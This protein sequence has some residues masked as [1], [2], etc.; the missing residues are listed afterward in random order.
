[1][2]VAQRSGR[3]RY[4]LVLLILTALA[5]LTLD[6]REFGPLG[7]AQSAVRDF[8]Q[9]GVNAVDTL[10]G[11]VA[12]VWTIM[13]V[14]NDLRNENVQLEAELDQLRSADITR[15]ATNAAL[16]SLL[17]ATEV[18]YLTDVEG[19]TAS[20]LRDA[21]GNFNDDMI[22]VDVGRRDGVTAG[23]AVVTG[24]GLV[25]RINDVDFSSSTVTTV[26]DP[27]LTI[28]V[29]L[30]DTGEVGLGHGVAGQ[31]ELFVV[32]TGLRWPESGDPAELPAIGSSVVTAAA[33]RY[34]ADVPVG[35]VIAVEEAEA[36]LLQRVTVELAVDTRDL[37]FVTV[38]LLPPADA[39]PDGPAPPFAEAVP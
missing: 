10:L 27:D 24:A 22:S 1:M 2:A 4:R 23:M 25:G 21:V 3:T 14:Y 26:S 36:G 31:A 20:V 6:F 28:G 16:A 15:D 7:A 32:D 30:L 39:A 19:V 18:D 9:P 37:A 34:P 8:L 17:A 38:L 35:R 12:D 13:F 11:P 5:L 33:S 29:R